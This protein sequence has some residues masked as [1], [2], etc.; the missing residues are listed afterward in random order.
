M[1][2][3]KTL[4]SQMMEFILWTKFSRIMQRNRENFGAVDVGGVWG[5]L[6]VNLLRLFLRKKLLHGGLVSQV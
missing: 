5:T 1:N 3:G 2:V 6:K 4:F